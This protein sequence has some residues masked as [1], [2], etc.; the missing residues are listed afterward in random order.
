MTRRALA[1][2]VITAAAA[3]GS[4]KSMM[5]EV[6]HATAVCAGGCDAGAAVAVGVPIRVK[7][8]WN[9][10]DSRDQQCDP[11]KPPFTI[12]TRCEGAHC[13]VED[14]G[15][16]DLLVTPTEAGDATIVLDLA[17]QKKRQIRLGP[18]TAMPVDGIDLICTMRRPG[19]D[20]GEPCGNAVPAGSDVH[21]EIVAKSGARRLVN[22]L[23]KDIAVDGRVVMK[24]GT[25]LGGAP[26]ECKASIDSSDPAI[27]TVRKCTRN[28]VA[29]GAHWTLE[30][31]LPALGI[32]RSIEIKVAK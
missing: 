4:L 24:D 3:C 21:V 28:A 6:K 12:A 9:H 26:W 7:V 20:A 27:P 29:R 16:G 31:R 22:A 11:D 19:G 32:A 5:S 2:I 18:V 1:G 14:T 23:P 8:D 30:A 13:D 25:M 17:D 10:C 15:A